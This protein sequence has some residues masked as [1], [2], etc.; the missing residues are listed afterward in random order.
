MEEREAVCPRGHR[1]DRARQGYVNLLCSQASSSKR[2]GDDRRMVEARRTFLS[3]GHYAPLLE[4]VAR[5]AAAAAPP[6][7]E[8]LDAGCGEGYYTEGIYRALA[9]A[10]KEVHVT[11]VDISKDALKAAA[12]RPFPHDTAVASV[13]SLPVRSGSCHMAVSLFAPC[14]AEEFHRVLLP[15]GSLIRVVP[16][17]RHLFGL[18]AAVYDAPYENPEEDE[19][20][21]GFTAPLRQELNWVLHLE[22]REDIAALF[23]MTPYYYKTSQADQAKAAA[24][25]RLDTELSFGILHY[26]KEA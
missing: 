14:A 23:E 8:L 24:L 2:H 10:G 7:C 16:L 26:R 1:F 22:S 20:L 9:E 11:A 18:K 5:T 3:H 21:P 4:Q 12:R 13:F 25:E 15:G 19:G 6:V 17:R